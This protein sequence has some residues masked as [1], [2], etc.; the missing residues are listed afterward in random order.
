MQQQFN[1]LKEIAG[2][3]ELTNY[4]LIHRI[5]A[6]KDFVSRLVSPHFELLYF[7]T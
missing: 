5:R 6:E 3:C 1:P 2:Q 7:F 4:F